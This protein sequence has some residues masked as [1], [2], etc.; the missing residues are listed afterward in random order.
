MA[1][2]TTAHRTV[3]IP[4]FEEATRLQ[5]P[6]VA[7]LV[8]ADRTHVLL[9]D[10]G[11]RD[12][13]P[14]LLRSL[15]EAHPGRVS[16]L[17]LGTNQG[18]GEAVRRGL[19][20]ALADGAGVVGFLDAD[21]ATPPREWL[22]MADHLEAERPETERLEVVLGARLLR[23]GARIERGTVRHVVG[24]LFATLASLRLEEPFYD[25]QCGAKAFRR[26]AALQ[27]ALAQPFRSRWA[28]DVELLSRLLEGEPPIPFEAMEEL[29]LRAWR[30]QS[31]SKLGLRSALGAT[32]EVVRLPRRRRGRR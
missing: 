19:L 4:C 13:T 26:S 14:A 16:V 5:P 25:T 27:A 24:R 31:G 10:D 2:A 7:T 12:G 9:V 28:F 22:R 17:T 23:A 1:S 6:G 21:F 3:V 30:D 29:P 15:A 32:L 18:K 11:S 20:Q 8:A